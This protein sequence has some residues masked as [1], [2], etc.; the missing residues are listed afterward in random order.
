MPKRTRE[1]LPA[2]LRRP[3]LSK[4]SDKE[5][6]DCLQKAFDSLSTEDQANVKQALKPLTDIRLM[7]LSSALRVA[8]VVTRAADL[9]R[10]DATLSIPRELDP[11][12]FSHR[13]GG[14][15]AA[16]RARRD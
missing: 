8:F 3:S 12:T 2:P 10:L 16:D 14:N 1:K 6:A 9:D 5:I 11:V 15:G 7:G 4:L 13:S